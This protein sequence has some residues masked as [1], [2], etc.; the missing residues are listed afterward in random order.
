[1]ITLVQFPWSPFCLVQRRILEYSGAKFK[2][3]NI[4]STD[5]TLVWRWTRQR[6][7]QVPILKDGRSVIFETDDDSQVIAKY[8]D[9]KYELGLFPRTWAGL[10]NVLWRHIE[11]EVEGLAFKLNDIYFREFVP[12]REQLD[13]IRHKERKFGRG[14][15]ERW[16]QQ[17]VTLVE[18]LARC[19]VPFEQML[20]TRPFLLEARVRFVDFDLYGMLAN[21]LYSGHYRLPEAHNHL[22]DWYQR[23]A[24]LSRAV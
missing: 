11:N 5:R 7:Y 18:E 8:L 9:A 10:Q 19:L 12:A 15:L 22:R 24:S 16:R 23:M 4:P 17:Q 13:F 20:A 21:Y 6:Y 3:V 2:L 1:M 14:C